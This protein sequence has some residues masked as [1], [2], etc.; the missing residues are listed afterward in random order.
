MLKH[1]DKVLIEIKIVQL[2]LYL[3]QRELEKQKS[4]RIPLIEIESH[5]N[6][7]LQSLNHLISYMDDFK[8]DAELNTSARHRTKEI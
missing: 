7:S 6:H 4:P 3:A 8:T 2:Q 5:I 1:L